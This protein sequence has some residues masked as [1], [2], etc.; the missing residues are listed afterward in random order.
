[1]KTQTTVVLNDLHGQFIDKVAFALALGFIKRQQPDNV[2]LNGDIVD[3]Y[4]IS[5]FDKDPLRLESLQD[6]LDFTITLSNKKYT[7]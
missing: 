6:E 5:N 3:F 7:G 2:V 1:M 4:K